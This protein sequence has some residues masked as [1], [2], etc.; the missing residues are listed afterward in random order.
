MAFQANRRL[1]WISSVLQTLWG[2]YLDCCALFYYL[3]KA[4]FYDRIVIDWNDLKHFLYVFGVTDAAR[5]ALIY[6]YSD[7][8]P[9]YT[10][11]EWLTA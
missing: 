10:E 2:A 5:R 7:E 11:W 1:R 4:V 8:E 6:R 3:R 9:T